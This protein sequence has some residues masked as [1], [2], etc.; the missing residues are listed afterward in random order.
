MADEK[1]IDDPAS[2]GLAVAP[3][4]PGGPDAERE[5]SAAV[6]GAGSG[7]DVRPANDA[8]TDRRL[9]SDPSDDPDAE[10]ARMAGKE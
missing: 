2:D 6:T 5:A 4:P 9:A 7:N 8:T 1:M 10:A 3:P